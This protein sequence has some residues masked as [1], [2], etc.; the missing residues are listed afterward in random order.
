[1]KKSVLTGPHDVQ[2]LTPGGERPAA[3]YYEEPHG[4]HIL[5]QVPG[6]STPRRMIIS[7]RKVS[8]SL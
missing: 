3:W 6:E 2:V 8:N 1:M 5:M 7:W 4:L